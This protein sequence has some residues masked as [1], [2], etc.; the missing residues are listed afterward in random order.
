M[1]WLPLLG[2]PGKHCA[3]YGRND[4]LDVAFMPAPEDLN[5]DPPAL[6]EPLDSLDL[7]E[8]VLVAGYPTAGKGP[9]RLSRAGSSRESM[10]MFGSTSTRPGGTR[11]AR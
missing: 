9:G 7:G 8:E 3:V 4:E 6:L 2:T 5:V 10:R 11:A 1:S